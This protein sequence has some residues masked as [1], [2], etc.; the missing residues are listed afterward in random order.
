MT[1][2]SVNLRSFNDIR[3]SCGIMAREN[4]IFVKL[5]VCL[6]HLKKLVKL[7]RLYQF[8]RIQVLKRSEDLSSIKMYQIANL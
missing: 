3:M 8:V 6:T 2:S 5:N 1:Y 4:K 7:R